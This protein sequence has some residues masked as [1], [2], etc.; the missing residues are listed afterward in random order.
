MIAIIEQ[1]REV[2][3]TSDNG[4]NRQAVG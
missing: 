2:P 4:P 1:S 3:E